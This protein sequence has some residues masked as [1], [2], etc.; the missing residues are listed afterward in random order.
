MWVAGMMVTICVSLVPGMRFLLTGDWYAVFGWGTGVVF[1]PALALALGVW[2]NGPRMF[3]MV[4]F[5]LWFLGIYSGGSIAMFDFLGRNQVNAQFGIPIY[6]I[7]LTAVLMIL[8]VTGRHK[9]I[10]SALK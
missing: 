4:Y 10:A 9:Q 7:L 8:A 2:T 1:V 6:Y 5:I 3:E